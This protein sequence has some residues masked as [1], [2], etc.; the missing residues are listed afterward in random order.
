[1]LKKF[2]TVGLALILGVTTLGT[3]IFATTRAVKENYTRKG[4]GYKEYTTNPDYAMITNGTDGEIW[5]VYNSKTEA[6]FYRFKNAVNE[7]YSEEIALNGANVPY[8]V[9]DNV[10]DCIFN[11]DPDEAF[12]FL[13]GFLGSAQEVDY[14]IAELAGIV[15]DILFYYDRLLPYE[16]PESKN[17]CVWNGGSWICKYSEGAL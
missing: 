5:I 14:K 2:L 11:N 15:D 3:S 16:A 4:Y 12:T 1:M 7:L 17:E 9:I 6:S 10:I 13:V 8:T